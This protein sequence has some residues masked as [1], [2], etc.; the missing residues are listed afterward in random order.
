MTVKHSILFVFTLL[1][2]SGCSSA[3]HRFIEPETATGQICVQKC[4]QAKDRCK[5]REERLYSTCKSVYGEQLQNYEI[6]ERAQGNL[7]FDCGIPN[8][9]PPPDKRMCMRHFTSCWESCG[10]KITA[11][12]Q[13]GLQ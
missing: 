1:I 4:M 11:Q 2:V 9:C 6:C 13:E 12:Q 7:P 10:G 5:A 3:M 8:L